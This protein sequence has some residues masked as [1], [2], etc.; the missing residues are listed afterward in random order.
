MTFREG[1]RLFGRVMLVAVSSNETRDPWSVERY[2]VSHSRRRQARSALGRARRPFGPALRLIPSECCVLR[3]FD[4]PTHLTRPVRGWTSI[5]SGEGAPAKRCAALRIE[6]PLSNSWT[7]R[8]LMPVG[9][10][11]AQEKL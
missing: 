7:V 8:H 11:P 5:G 6:L 4:R 2:Q 1:Q 10:M 9:S 3:G